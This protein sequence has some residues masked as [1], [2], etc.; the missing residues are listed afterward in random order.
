MVEATVTPRNKLRRRHL[1]AAALLLLAAVASFEAYRAWQIVGDVRDGR[2]MLLRA[3]L[4]MDARRLDSEPVTMAD[5]RSDFA[6]AE[7][8]FAR[9]EARLRADAA[10]SIGRRLPWLGSQIEA[11]ETLT[12]IGQEGARIGVQGVDAIAAFQAV[13]D[14]GAQSLPELTPHLIAEVDPHIEQAST[15]LALID[16]ERDSL[17]TDG[18]LPPLAAAIGELDGRRERLRTMFEN[19]R[20]ARDFAPEF[21]GF[22]GRRTYLVLAHNNAEILPTGGLVSV[23]GTL[24]LDEGRVEEL[25]FHDA[26]QMGDDWMAREDVYVEPPAPLRQYLLKEHSWNLT[27]SNWS[28][29][30]PTAAERAAYFYALQGGDR[31]VDGVIAVN[32]TTLERLLAVTGA[33]AIPEFGVTVDATNAFDLTEQHTRVPFLP[34][35]DRKEFAA[36]LADEVLQR[37]LH[38]QAGQWSPLVETVQV[39]G[40]E[41]DLMLF[42]FNAEQQSLIEEMEWDGGTGSEKAS[43]TGQLTDYLM[44]VDASVNSTKLNWIIEH[45]AQIE[46]VLAEDG[47]ATTTVTLDYANPVG[48]WANGRDE[49]IIDKLM[50]GGQYGGYVRLFTP[51]GSRILSVTDGEQEIGL[52]EVASE[53]GLSVFGRFFALQADDRARLVFTYETPRVAVE[54]DGAL[55]YALHVQRQPGWVLDEVTVTVTPPAGMRQRSAMVD[56]AEMASAG[57]ID[58]DLSQ[59]RLVTVVFERE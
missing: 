36:L 32:V 15:S 2:E 6:D 13:R 28:P 49:Y 57:A 12:V 51:D 9:A 20:L 52:E 35:A 33:V 59:D 46:V 19:Y 53:Q 24:V 27:T 21:L 43:G 8:S 58:V 47:T 26:V 45:D 17:A 7:S 23:V 1:V 41:K 29:D 18:L 30:F 14:G 11:A 4:R 42:S 56:D 54:R 44:V 31:P 38:P 10:V 40:D 16:A 25:E 3:E 48:E 55:T 22:E 37:V 5:A 50:L 39:L 34:A